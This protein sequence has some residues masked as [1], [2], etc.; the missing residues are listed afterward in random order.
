M[1]VLFLGTLM[2]TGL[3]AGNPTSCLSF[4]SLEGITSY[5]AGEGLDVTVK[6]HTCL[7]S[8]SEDKKT[9]GSES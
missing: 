9:K 5:P 6:C 8:K 1:I 7:H 2:K 4:E 3:P